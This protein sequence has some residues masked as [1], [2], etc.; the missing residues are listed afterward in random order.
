MYHRYYFANLTVVDDSLN[1]SFITEK[2]V[3]KKIDTHKLNQNGEELKFKPG[4]IYFSILL[5]SL[6]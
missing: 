3:V 6:N 1:Y 2:L 4:T 5:I